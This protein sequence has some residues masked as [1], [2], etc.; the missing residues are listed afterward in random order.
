MARAKTT[1]AKS[2]TAEPKVYR[3]SDS[4]GDMDTWYDYNTVEDAV[5]DLE[6]TFSN[7]DYAEG[8]EVVV[9]QVVKRGTIRRK[10]TFIDWE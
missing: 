7:H 6:N 2:N 10:E 8:E 3:V 4:Y 1:K 9:M 5:T